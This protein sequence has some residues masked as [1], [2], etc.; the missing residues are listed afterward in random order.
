VGRHGAVVSATVL[1]T[2][3][4]RGELTRGGGR[5]PIPPLI[6][7]RRQNNAVKLTASVGIHEF[8]SGK[9]AKTFGYSGPILG[10][11]L[12]SRRGG[13]EMSVRNELGVATSVHWH[14]LLVPGHPMASLSENRA[15]RDLGDP[16]SR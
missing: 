1:D 13:V 8:L 14:G 2:R 7:A 12:R 6:D 16:C 15:G 4:V 3:F 11:V 10:P 5:L 9:P